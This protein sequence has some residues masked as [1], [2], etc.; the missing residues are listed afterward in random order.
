[1]CAAVAGTLASLQVHSELAFVAVLSA[2]GAGPAMNLGR[3][4]RS[5][6]SHLFHVAAPLQYKLT[7]IYS[8]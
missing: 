2:P 6:P 1:V 3:D 8:I 7:D 5:T 4:E